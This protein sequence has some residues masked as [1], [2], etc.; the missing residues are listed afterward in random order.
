M[1]LA[2]GC[3]FAGYGPFFSI[4]PEILPRRVAGEAMALVNSLGALGGFAGTYIVGWLNSA[5][6]G[7]GASFLF[8]AASLAA[9]G[10]CMIIVR[11]RPMPAPG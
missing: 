9:A 3:I 7:P 1:I 5:T 10:L 11:T 8:L 4:V 2:G 6:G